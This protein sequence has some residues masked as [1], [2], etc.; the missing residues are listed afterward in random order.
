M[1]W[2][3]K[4][5]LEP[6]DPQYSK[7]KEGKIK[8]YICKSCGNSLKEDAIKSTGINPNI[9]DGHGHDKLVP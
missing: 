9:L 7:M 4:F 5:L 1:S 2:A 8:L 3:K 6:S